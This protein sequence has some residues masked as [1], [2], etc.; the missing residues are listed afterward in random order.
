MK[1][2]YIYIVILIAI[3]VSFIPFNLELSP[4][5]HLKIID[6]NKA[7]MI[8]AIVRQTWYQYSL[9]IR[10]EVDVPVSKMG[11]VTLY[12]RLVRTNALSIIMGAIKQ[13]RDLGLHASIWTDE[14]V[15]VFAQGYEDKWFHGGTAPKTG[16]ILLREK[17]LGRGGHP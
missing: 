16:S 7:P 4:E 17:R 14:S 2:N 11:E 1:K 8:D 13:F 9:E 5:R 6:L 3:V 15:G 12:R 10:G